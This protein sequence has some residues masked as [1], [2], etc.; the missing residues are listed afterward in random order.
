MS[1]AEMGSQ[2]QQVCVWGGQWGWGRADKVAFW[3]R[4]ECGCSTSTTS[5][6]VQQASGPHMERELVFIKNNETSVKRLLANFP[7][8]TI[9][10]SPAMLTNRNPMPQLKVWPEI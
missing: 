1:L 6:D 3:M 2:E 8:Q 4:V 7:S 5:G 10:E 9:P